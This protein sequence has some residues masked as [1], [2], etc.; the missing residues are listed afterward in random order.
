[1]RLS[2]F[3]TIKGLIALAF[4]IA[5][6]VVPA[7]VGNLY[8]M[9]MNDVALYLAN[10]LGGMMI[11]VG[12]ACLLFRRM[13]GDA[14]RALTLSFFVGDAVACLAG[15]VYQFKPVATNAGWVN[16]AI[17]GLLAIGLAY[18]RFVRYAR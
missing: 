18:Y 17:F 15:L 8:S 14:A 3:L 16:V 13:E 7:E 12:M 4:G 10:F 5:L 9:T 2:T 6:V 11:C 1:M